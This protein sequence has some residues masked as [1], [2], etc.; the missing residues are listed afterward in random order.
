MYYK[1]KD[2]ESMVELK[3]RSLKLR[4]LMV[5][6]KYKFQKDLLYK[7][8]KRWYIDDSI[9]FEFD[10]KRKSLNSYNFQSFVSISFDG[11]KSIDYINEL[12]KLVHTKIT[13]KNQG[14]VIYYVIEPN[15]TQNNHLHFLINIPFNV[16]NRKMI[17]NEFK[18]FGVNF[19]ME[20][21]TNYRNLQNYL[22]K[23]FVYKKLLW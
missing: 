12:I 21:I 14:V 17:Y 19:H 22:K 20:K 11:S 5:K 23:D 10:R 4:M 8:G 2:L 3:P 18:L 1:L 6:E 9:I 7:E 15:F 13:S 16:P